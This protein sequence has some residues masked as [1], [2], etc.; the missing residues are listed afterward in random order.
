MSE[1]QT[2][3]ENDEPAVPTSPEPQPQFQG[4]NPQGDEYDLD[5]EVD[6]DEGAVTEPN[7]D[8]DV[9]RPEGGLVYDDEDGDT[10]AEPN[11]DADESNEDGV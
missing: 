3:V 10:D 7:D 2:P 9:V 8:E 1:E 4:L 6:V 5:G 11:F